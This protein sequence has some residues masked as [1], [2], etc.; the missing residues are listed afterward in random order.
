MNPATIGAIAAA[1]GVPI[2]FAI[3]G[4]FFPPSNIDPNGPSLEVL[5]QRF[6]N[7]EMAISL[8][9]IVMCVPIG[10]TLW[11]G[12]RGLSA[13]HASLLPTAPIVL[14]AMSIYWAL[15]AMFLSM[16]CADL[17]M[18]AILKRM[19][20]DEYADF[21][22]YQALKYQMNP[23]RVS[24]VLMTGVGA[25]C[26]IAVLLGLNWYVV[27]TEREFV[28]NRFLSL[29]EERYAISSIET[30]R[31]APTLIAPN[32]NVVS[33]REYVVRFSGGARWSTSDSPA[34]LDEDA[35][36]S[37]M[38]RL[39]GSSGVAIEEVDVFERGEW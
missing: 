5:R 15:P 33:R 3:L 9:Y 28:V 20:G 11:Y 30:I 25:L 32:G 24:R 38:Q 18:T 23:E 35:K 19:L 10:L 1:I 31:T 39:S 29:T 36:A 7:R 13:W 12:F 17:P 34:D 14:T 26:G 6:K 22:R 4:K 27:V 8:G 37:L 21:H 16:V 2:A